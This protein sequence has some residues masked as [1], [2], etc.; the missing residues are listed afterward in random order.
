ML[1]TT[2][3]RQMAC[4]FFISIL[5]TLWIANP[6]VTAKTLFQSPA[7]PVS[8]PAE[9]AQQPPSAEQSPI[10]APQEQA[11]Q[12]PGVEQESGV[13][14]LAPTLPAE[15]TGS[16]PIAPEEAQPESSRPSRDRDSRNPADEETDSPNF[17]LDRVEFIDSV[18]VS[19]AYLWLCCGV[20]LFLLVPIFMLVLYIRGRSKMSQNDR[21]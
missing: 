16:A 4:L 10:S 2:G 15:T 17:I 3:M 8:P 11:P 19:G 12:Q 20:A 5:F 1:P 18:V 9:P 7:S 6:G 13:E 21:F 14:S